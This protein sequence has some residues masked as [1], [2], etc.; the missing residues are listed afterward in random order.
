MDTKHQQ[1]I[2]HIRSLME[3]SSRFISLSGLSGIC[4]GIFALVAAGS[5][6]HFLKQSGISCFRNTTALYTHDLLMQLIATGV[7]AFIAAL[8]SGIYFTVRKSRKNGLPAWNSISKRLVISLCVPLLAGG[9]F[10]LALLYNMQYAFVAPATL[11]FYGLALINASKFTFSDIIYLGYCELA[12]GLIAMFC[13]GWGLLFWA[14]GFGL[15][16]I[17]YGVVMYKKYK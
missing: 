14:A 10:C 1:D 4:S 13:L 12:L 2:E 11:I 15:L 8:G 6:A 17:I 5:A 3:R 7:L 9:I 16:H